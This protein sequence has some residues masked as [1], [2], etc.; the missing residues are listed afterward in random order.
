M[1]FAVRMYPRPV[2]RAS[3]IC[4]ASPVLKNVVRPGCFENVYRSGA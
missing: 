1:L 4:F 3:D 2:G